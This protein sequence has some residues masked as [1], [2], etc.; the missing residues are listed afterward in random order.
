M[1]ERECRKRWNADEEFLCVTR[2]GLIFV[3]VVFGF[4]GFISIYLCS[5][6]H[7]PSMWTGQHCT[8]I[9]QSQHCI[10]HGYIH[11]LVLRVSPVLNQQNTRPGA[12]CGSFYIAQCAYFCKTSYPL[13]RTTAD[14]YI[15]FFRYRTTAQ[16]QAR[17]AQGL[18][19][20]L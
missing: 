12:L 18:R 1:E 17:S 16:R 3:V 14:N 13:K 19:T 5:V 15:V 2:A 9:S 8:A 10:F 6:Q 7:S 4:S 20:G 11:A